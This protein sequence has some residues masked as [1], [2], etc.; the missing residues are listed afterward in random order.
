MNK[1]LILGFGVASTAYISLLDHNKK[2]VSVLGTPYD[3]KKIK[4]LNNSKIKKDKNFG[5]VFSN[6]I[7][8]YKSIDDINKSKY[9]LI[10]VAVNSNG[11]LWASKQLKQLK[12]SCPILILTKGLFKLKKNIYK[13][14]DFFKLKNNLK[15]IVYVAG[16]CLAG[17]LIKKTHTRTVL[18]SSTIADSRYVKKILQNEY[19]HPEISTD[20]VGA[21][22]CAATKNIYATII[23]SAIGQA[24]DY[25]SESN[26]AKNYFNAASALFQQSI[27]EMNEIVKKFNGKT[28]TVLGPAGTGD[29]YVS[30]LGGRNSKMGAFLGKGLL[31]KNIINSKMKG[32][33][34][35]GSELM[36][37]V[38]P[39]LLNYVGKQKL[40]LASLL[41]DSLIKNKKLNIDWKKITN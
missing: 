32:I 22:I 38:G 18:A 37:D 26:K 20:I 4:N 36:L 17:E 35:E 21:E 40:P 10:V 9:S 19:Y 34:V 29:L 5:L 7:N 28:S 31:Y 41:L 14:S 6:N 13:L 16:P 25:L 33:T 30:A 27:H 8:F 1:I 12:I 23:G 3:F 11:I 2:K 24:N 15:R 39:L